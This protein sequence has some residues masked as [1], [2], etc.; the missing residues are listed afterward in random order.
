MR[1]H[2]TVY[3]AM[4]TVQADA[5]LH[6]VR[7]GANGRPMCGRSSLSGKTA[8]LHSMN[9]LIVHYLC[10]MTSLYALEVLFVAQVQLMIG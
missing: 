5:V 3:A 2:W 4:L 7:A 10:I 6:A 1:A 8:G 9:G